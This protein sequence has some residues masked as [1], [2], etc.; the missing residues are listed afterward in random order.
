MILNN[1]QKREM[2]R[3]YPKGWELLD[4]P[5]FWRNVEDGDDDENDYSPNFPLGGVCEIY[6]IRVEDELTV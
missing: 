4:I 3:V 6:D 5:T 1:E 2:E